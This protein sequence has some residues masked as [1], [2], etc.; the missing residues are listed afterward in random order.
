M[1]L[2]CTQRCQGCPVNRVLA[3]FLMKKHHHSNLKTRY[4][5]NSNDIDI[6]SMAKHDRAG[7]WSSPTGAAQVWSRTS[8]SLSFWCLCLETCRTSPSLQRVNMSQRRL[9]RRRNNDVH[10]LGPVRR[11]EEDLLWKSSGY[12]VDGFPLDRF[13]HG[14]QHAVTCMLRSFYCQN[15]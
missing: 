4:Q 1:P 13:P 11:W 3:V 9:L 15:Q 5:M 7:D 12:H 2:H 6:Y 14:N 10:V 8:R